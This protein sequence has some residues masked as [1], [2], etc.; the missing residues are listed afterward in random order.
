MQSLQVV[1]KTKINTSLIITKLLY[2]TYQFCISYIIMH[3]ITGVYGSKFSISPGIAIIRVS[4]E[5]ECV[6]CGAVV[7]HAVLCH[8]SPPSWGGEGEELHPSAP[9][10]EVEGQQ[11]GQL[12]PPL[13]EVQRSNRPLMTR[14]RSEHDCP[15]LETSK[16]MYGRR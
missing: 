10:A 9:L 4:Y 13:G 16:S 3:L 2:Y 15:S 7:G 8:P 12:L 5:G 6:P 1:S 11:C 14:E